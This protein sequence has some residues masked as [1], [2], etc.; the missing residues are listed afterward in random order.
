MNFFRVWFLAA[1]PKTLWAS[2]SPVLLGSALALDAGSFHAPAAMAAL[3]GAMLIQ[4]GAN[5]ANDYFDFIK[6]ADTEARLGPQR[7]TQSGWVTP[8]QMR[9]ATILVFALAFLVGL[10]LVYRGGWPILLIGLISIACGVLYTGG[11]Y[12]LGYIGL[13]DVFAFVFFGPVAVAGTYYVQVLQWDALPVWVGMAPGFF[14]LALLTVNN[15]RDREEDQQSGKKTLAVR[16][17]KRFAQGEY[18]LALLSAT[19]LTPLCIHTFYPGHGWALL[20]CHA[21]LLA[22]VSIQKVFHLGGGPELNT[23]LAATGKL[24]LFFSVLYSVGWLL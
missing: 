13:A 17:G 16:F 18:T 21:A 7:A 20:A 12:P 10:Y 15:L 24:Q 1:R 22:L 3:I 14:S 5:F 9:R 19:L 8:I 11:P 6:G 4:I 2:V 23:V